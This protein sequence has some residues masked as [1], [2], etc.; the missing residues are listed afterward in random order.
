MGTLLQRHEVPPPKKKNL[1]TFP[2]KVLTRVD[3]LEQATPSIEGSTGK[4][5]FKKV[6]RDGGTSYTRGRKRTYGEI[7]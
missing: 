6:N 2:A 3:A 4:V 1:S 5:V 7:L